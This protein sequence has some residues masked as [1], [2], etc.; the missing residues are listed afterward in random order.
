MNQKISVIHKK[1]VCGDN[2]LSMEN[3]IPKIWMILFIFQIAF[4]RYLKLYFT[5]IYYYY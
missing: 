5:Q 2:S 4:F 1:E 3:S